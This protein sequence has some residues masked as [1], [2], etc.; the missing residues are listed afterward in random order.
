MGKYV[1]YSILYTVVDTH[2]HIYIR[3]HTSD[4]RIYLDARRLAVKKTRTRV[5]FNDR[6][7]SMV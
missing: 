7:R 6:C 1:L 5:A 4:I 2:M 3:I